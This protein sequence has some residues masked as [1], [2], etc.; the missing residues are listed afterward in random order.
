MC[1]HSSTSYVVVFVAGEGDALTVQCDI[2]GACLPG[3]AIPADIYD[4][5]QYGGVRYPQVDQAAY[6]RAV[7]GSLRR[8]LDDAHDLGVFA[9][10]AGR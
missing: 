9:K 2:C 1:K 3:A 6:D 4:G 7:D 10:V 8:G 5:W